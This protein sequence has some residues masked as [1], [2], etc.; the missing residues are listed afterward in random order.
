MPEQGEKLCNRITQLF[1]TTHSSARLIKMPFPRWE[2]QGC[3]C[4]GVVVQVV[5]GIQLGKEKAFVRALVSLR[6]SH[7]GAQKF[8]EVISQGDS[9][10]TT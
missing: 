2:L 9:S 1:M 4:R 8:S 7:L 5:L 6:C 3:S 10:R